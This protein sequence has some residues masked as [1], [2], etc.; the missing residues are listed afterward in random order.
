MAETFFSNFNSQSFQSQLGNVAQLNNFA[1]SITLP[2]AIAT[3]IP[4]S[5][6][7]ARKVSFAIRAAEKPEMSIGEISL[8]F[9]GGAR[10]RIPGDRDFTA[11]WNVTARFDINNTVYNCFEAWSDAIVGNVDSDTAVADDDVM[12][13]MGVGE[14][15]QLSRN[16]RIIKG[17]SI[18]GIWPSV[19]G[20]ISYD[21]SAENAVVEVPIT[22]V[23]S[24]ME[25]EVTRNNIISEQE[26]LSGTVVF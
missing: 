3:L 20:S 17:W 24:H 26:L 4:N 15:F 5:D 6:Q 16:G 11:T 1:A 19:V 12:Q 18:A 21:W 2:A 8:P 14:L 7:F 25:S 10:F 13:V 22:F 9:R 23:M